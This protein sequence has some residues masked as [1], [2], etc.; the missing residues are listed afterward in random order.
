MNVIRHVGDTFLLYDPDGEVISNLGSGIEIQLRRVI[1]QN[2]TREIMDLRYVVDITKSTI[3]NNE[4]FSSNSVA[5][6]IIPLGTS[7][8]NICMS[9]FQEQAFGMVH[10]LG[11]QPYQV[12]KQ[13]AGHVLVINGLLWD[14]RL[15]H[16]KDICV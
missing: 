5:L 14:G 1:T 13:P 12:P 3:H 7:D 9:V 8:A 4:P 10:R 16:V 2:S 11:L 6:F 15:L